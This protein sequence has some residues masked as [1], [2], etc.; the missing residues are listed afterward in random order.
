M[1]GASVV[2]TLRPVCRFCATLYVCTTLHATKHL[3]NFGET[4]LCFM[5]KLFSVFSSHVLWLLCVVYRVSG[6]TL[7]HVL[8]N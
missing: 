7:K 4:G 8:G 1:N 5:K 6:W 2:P 3:I